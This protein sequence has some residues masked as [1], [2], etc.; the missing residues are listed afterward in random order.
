MQTNRIFGFDGI[1]AVSVL[2]VIASHVGIV[3]AAKNPAMIRFFSVF[4][5]SFGV[6]CFFVLSGFLITTLLVKEYERR[7]TVDIRSFMVR[8]ALRILPLY[9]VV[10]LS[11]WPFVE[12]GRRWEPLYTASYAV[13]FVYNFIPHELNVHYLSHLW[14]L[15]VE[16]Q[17]YILWPLLFGLLAAKRRWLLVIC[18]A[19]VAI[20]TIRMSIGYGEAAVSYSPNRW[21]IPAIYPIAL[22]AGLA[23]LFADKK[24]GSAA[25]AFVSS[26]TAAAL[27]TV[28]ICLP[29]LHIN[30]AI[31]EVLGAIG[32][33]AIIG[34]IYTNQHRQVVKWMEWAPLKYV[35]TI[36]F[37]LYMWQGVLTGNGSYRQL[38]TFPPDPITGAMLTFPIAIISYHC[39]ERPISS[40]RRFIPQGQLVRPTA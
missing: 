1:R 17:Y 40:L 15:G 18:G 5:A 3:E 34:W 36:S 16:E 30:S 2:L 21:T 22:G 9:F 13:F 20:C 32:I 6:R 26:P 14:S 11:L 28:L 39:F 8:R 31:V 27:A 35:G 24:I 33:T 25:R 12:A 37:G 38:L 7:G 29:L 10:L 4:N 19:I 23:I